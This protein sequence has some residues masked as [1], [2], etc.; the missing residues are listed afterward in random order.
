MRKIVSSLRT[1]VAQLLLAF[2]LAWALPTF[3]QAPQPARAFDPQLALP[4]D[5]AVQRGTL[6]NGVEFFIRQ[7]LRPARRVLFRLAVKAGSVLEADDQRGLAHLVEH[8]A[9]NGSTHFKPGELVSYFESTGARLGP[10]VNAYTSFDETVYMLELPTDTPDIVTQGLTALADF[11]GGLTLDPEQVDK[12]RGVVIEEWRGRLGAGSRIRDTQLPFIFY[13]SRYADR[14]PIGKPEVLRDAPAHRL[15]AFYDTWYRPDR[16]AVVVVGDIDPQQIETTI[17]EAFLPLTTR[18]VAAPLPRTAVPLHDETLVSVVTDPEVTSSSIRVMRKRPSESRTLVGDYRRSLVER[19]FERMFN[20]RFGELAQKPDAAFLGAAARHGLLTPTV[21]T[22][23]L[24]AR[25]PDGGI[26]AGLGALVVESRRAIEF[27]FAPSELDRAKRWM[28]AFYERAYNERDKSESD[29]FADE[30]LRHFLNGEPIP[31]IEYEYQ[32]TQS[33]LE[34][35]TIE[36]VTA[37]ARSRLADNGRVVLAVAPEKAGAPAPSEEDLRGAIS[38]AGKVVVTAWSDTTTTRA[39]METLPEPEPVESRREREEVGVTIV[40]FANGLEAW[41]KPTD[42][43]NDQVLFTMYSMGGASLA[44]QADFV[45]ATLAA[46]YVS[47]SGVGGLRALELQRV[48]TGKLV[49]VAPF[50]SISTHGVSGSAAPAE[51]E[52][53]LQLLYQTIRTP[54][55]D[56]DAFALMKR[57]LEASVANRERSPGRVFSERV[58]QLNTSNHYSAQPLTS[59]RVATIERTKML[60]FYRN[61]FRN[62]ADFTMFIVG[63][64]KVET[65]IPLLARYVGSLPTSGK[66][67]AQDKDIG[68]RFPATSVREVVERGREP[69]SQTVISFFADPSPDPVEQERVGAAR[70]VLEMALRDILREDIGQ[71][72]TVSVR[73]AQS[74]PPRGEGR[75]RVS[76]GASPDNIQPMIERVLQEVGRLQQVGPS[77]DLTSR[78]REAA[79]RGYE[80]ALAQNPYWLQRMRTVHMLD[81][82]PFEILTRTERIDAITPAVVQEAF[83]KYFPPD[84]YT[85]VTLVPEKTQ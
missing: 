1:G 25:V 85:V 24:S 71:T 9:F 54:G 77:A 53:A 6:S 69:R 31:G 3:A 84:R 43:K 17:R 55:D 52:T 8:M 21:D 41:L 48:L 22:F 51:L 73:L 13:Q 14:L 74:F 15:R 80:T 16:M 39:L 38:A 2:A 37:L 29:S 27:G 62:A 30:Y 59:E 60:D 57:R 33:L 47:L 83:K 64:F 32:L 34:G 76:F 79:R 78:A 23:S 18:T 81:R 45:E 44:P 66:R 50:I 49:S 75:I 56:P 67:R 68:V 26:A 35:I 40:R 10:H 20:D 82:N 42:F 12:E 72:Y 7:N 46:Q 65:T 70:T 5:P 58:A 19:L 63:A 28:A 11:A 61:R 36:E 4:F